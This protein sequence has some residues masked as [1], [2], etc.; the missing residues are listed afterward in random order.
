[1]TGWLVFELCVCD[2]LGSGC[3]L[4]VAGVVF[5]LSFASLV[6]FLCSRCKVG[7]VG[8]SGGGVFC[9]RL[10]LGSLVQ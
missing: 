5:A 8:C 2:G 9:D 3:E 10:S 4:C 7:V 6:L 1:M